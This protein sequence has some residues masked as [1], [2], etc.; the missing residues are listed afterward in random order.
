MITTRRVY[1][2]PGSKDGFRILV[3][4]LWPRG[5]SKEKACIDEWRKDLAPS[6]R[7]RKWF[8]HEAEKWDEFRRRYHRELAAKLTAVKEF[9]RQRQPKNITLVY[10][11]RDEQHNNAVALKE[12]LEFRGRAAGRKKTARYRSQQASR[13]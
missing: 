4:R 5:I 2:P 9:V 10:G 13:R 12:F 8:N 6:D 3:D 11:A 7:L 1:E